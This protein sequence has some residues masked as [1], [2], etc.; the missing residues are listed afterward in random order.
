[1]SVLPLAPFMR[2]ARLTTLALVVLAAGLVAGC[3]SSSGDGNADPARVAPK[4]SAAYAVGTVSP[5]GSQRDA[6]NS[7]A[8]KLFGANDPGKS[9]SQAIQRSIN[10]SSNTSKLDFEKDVKPWLGKRAAVAVTQVQAGRKGVTGAVIVASKDLDATRAALKK[11]ERGESVRKSYRGVNFDVDQSD[12]S[13]TGIVGG[14]LVQGFQP[15]GFRA[16][17]DA[18]K[19]GG[20]V[21]APSFQGA[22]RRGQDKLAMA[23]VDLKTF[24]GT[25]LQLLPPAQRSTVLGALGGANAQPLTAT[26]DAKD[27][28]VSVE[29]VAPTGTA[30]KRSPGAGGTPVIAGLPGDSFAAFGIPRIGQTLTTTLRNFESG[31]A[32]AAIGPVKAAVAKRTGL[33]LE[34]DILAAV[35]DVGVFARGNSL[36]NVGAGVVIE[37]PNPAA[38]RRVV[39]KLGAFITR[40]GAASGIKAVATR[41][42]GAQGVKIT[43][44]RLPGAIN[45]VVKGAK[46]VLAYG[47]PATTQALS[48]STKL[49][50]SGSY[51]RAQTSLGGIP[52][53]LLVDFAPILSLA[54]AANSGSTSSSFTRVKQVLGSLDTLALGGRMEGNQQLVRFVLRVK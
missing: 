15:D 25:A 26:V 41:V 24:A 42:G 20:L 10:G 33:D 50:E 30:A 21:D 1:M 47:D 43:T 39:S 54:E 36:I 40:Q 38:A 5:D 12:Q 22:K 48:P 46:L 35:G 13:A 7:I 19:D 32:G 8:R 3:G 27:D 6:V 37:A 23:Y 4:G 29:L 49:S 18:S 34:R 44:P 52:P 2:F 45:F 53:S 14:F 11:A 16:V 9:I 28:A 17:V 31:L 51:R